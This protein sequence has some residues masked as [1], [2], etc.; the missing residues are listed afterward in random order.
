MQQAQPCSRCQG[1]RREHQAGR[2]GPGASPKGMAFPHLTGPSKAVGSVAR[3]TD[4]ITSYH[5]FIAADGPLVS[6]GS[7]VCVNS[8]EHSDCEKEHLCGMIVCM[9]GNNLRPDTMS[10]C[11]CGSNLKSCMRMHAISLRDLH[12]SI[13]HCPKMLAFVFVVSRMVYLTVGLTIPHEF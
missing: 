4:S 10:L 3:Q 6:L 13:Y 2:V 5:P 9:L 7:L 1:T 11:L 8:R 12:N